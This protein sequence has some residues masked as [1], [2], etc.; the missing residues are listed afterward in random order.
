MAKKTVYFEV[1]GKTGAGPG[2]AE[3]A[4]VTAFDTD[5]KTGAE[6]EI[7]PV[8]VS[9]ADLPIQFTVSPARLA[10]K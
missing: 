8:E 1:V 4:P 10:P 2:E 5:G 3:A 6:Q 7:V 9:P